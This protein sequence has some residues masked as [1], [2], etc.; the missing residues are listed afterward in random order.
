M[1]MANVYVNDKCVANYAYDNP[2]DGYT[3]LFSESE[4]TKEHFEHFPTRESM[5]QEF[6]FLFGKGNWDNY[7][8]PNN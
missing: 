7:L 1:K 6:D 5:V 4:T 8:T 3:V 2:S